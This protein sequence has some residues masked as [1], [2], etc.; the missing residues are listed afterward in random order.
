LATTLTV[1][2]GLTACTTL[3]PMPG[4]TMADPV[5]DGR[6][7]VEAQAGVVPGF[8]LSDSVQESPDSD[9]LGQLS[10]FFEPGELISL[11]G[12][13]AGARWVTGGDDGGYFEPMLRYRAFL[14]EA[15]RISLAGLAFAT[16]T[17]GSSGGAS[18]DIFRAGAE[19]SLAV[20]ATPESQFVELQLL[21][22]ASL[23]GIVGD[24]AFCMD[25]DTGY[26]VDCAEGQTAQTVAE[27][28]G[29]YPTA[30]AG[31]SL[32]FARHTEMIL[33]D[34]RLGAYV[35]GGAMPR[36]RFGEQEG[37]GTWFGGGLVL[38]VG[39]GAVD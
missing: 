26:G 33:H 21:G 3:G 39:V 13:A 15:Q 5:P 30:F 28:D 24:G 6:A 12:L 11:E 37:S 19:V 35:A 2:A 18:Y 22:G 27:V 9:T 8:F 4:L 31:L 14:D 10:A 7:E 38:S 25:A 36:I 29:A 20:R 32:D 16:A 23:T 1:A 17:S 34:V